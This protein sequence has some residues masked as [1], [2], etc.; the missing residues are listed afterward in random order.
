MNQKKDRIEEIIR[1][2]YQLDFEKVFNKAFENYKKIALY[3]GLMIFVF[4]VI[5]MTIA[6]SITISLLGLAA[7]SQESMKELS[8]NLESLSGLNLIIY[9]GASVLFS[10]LTS[11][12]T[13]G[14]IKMAYCADRD[15]EF[16][17][18]TVFSYYTPKYFSQIFTATFL[19]LLVSNGVSMLLNYSG[20]ILVGPMISVAVSFF[21]ML[22]IP[23]IIF[24]DL[25]AVDAIRYSFSIVLK[26]PLILLALII[27]AIIGAMVGF[28]GCCI[29]VFFTIPFV[30]SMYYAMYSEIIGFDHEEEL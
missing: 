3:A 6:A 1:N 19:I 24:S 25:T 11:P 16:H 12:L 22:T 26:Q 2:G 4:T 20:V 9:V 27:V 5:L 30:Y 10:S 28:I 17:V 14:L 21:T 15:E 29:G 13:A 18:S 23:L 7:L 8:I